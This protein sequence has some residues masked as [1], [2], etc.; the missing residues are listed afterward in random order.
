MSLLYVLLVW[1]G[2]ALAVGVCSLL[3]WLRD[4][5]R[6]QDDSSRVF[7]RRS[8]SQ[9]PLA[10]AKQTPEPVATNTIK[11]DLDPKPETVVRVEPCREAHAGGARRREVA[12][13]RVDRTLTYVNAACLG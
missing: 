4:F 11:E 6:D 5:D 2:L 3:R 12:R 9:Q 10:N 8:R 13:T 1:F 7:G